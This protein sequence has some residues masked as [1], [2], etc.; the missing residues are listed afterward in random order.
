MPIKKTY[1]SKNTCDNFSDF[2]G[3]EKQKR[4]SDPPLRMRMQ[5]LA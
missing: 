1:R 3:N 4:W 5:V 2:Y